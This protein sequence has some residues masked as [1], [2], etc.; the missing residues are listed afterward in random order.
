[1]TFECTFIKFAKAGAREWRLHQIV[2]K[3]LNIF[4]VA[5]RTH[6][7]IID[8][9]AED[10]KVESDHLRRDTKG[11]TWKAE[12]PSKIADANLE[13]RAWY[14][15]ADNMGKLMG[16]FLRTCETT[17]PKS[18]GVAFD[19]VR[20]VVLTCRFLSRRIRA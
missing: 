12:W 9:L 1:M 8:V 14:D 4:D 16:L 13:L 3:I 7:S 17:K 6:D 2:R 15:N 11:S 5:A 20:F 19:D 18:R 10:A